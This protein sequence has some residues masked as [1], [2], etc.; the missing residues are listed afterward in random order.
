MADQPAPSAQGT[1]TQ[2]WSQQQQQ[3]EQQSREQPANETGNRPTNGLPPVLS[4]NQCPIPPTVKIVLDYRKG[5]PRGSWRLL[6]ELPPSLPWVFNR[7]QDSFG[8]LLARIDSY[9]SRLPNVVLRPDGGPYLQPTHNTYQKNFVE[10]TEDNY[11]KEFESTWRK[12]ARRLNNIKGDQIVLHLYLY[13]RNADGSSGGMEGEPSPEPAMVASN[14][15][16]GSAMRSSITGSS[17]GLSGSGL[18]NVIRS[19]GGGGSGLG[20]GSS[21]SSILSRHTTATNGIRKSTVGSSLGG[22]GSSHG[23]VHAGRGQGRV[24]LVYGV[25]QATIDRINRA[26]EIQAVAA[27]EGF[28]PWPGPL[29]KVELARHMASA[30]RMPE[31][32]EVRIPE[33]ETFRQLRVLDQ[34]N[35]L[36][37]RDRF[38]GN[39]SGSHSGRT[40]EEEPS[41]NFAAAITS[42]ESVEPWEQEQEQEQVEEQAQEGDED[43]FVQMNIRIHGAIV[44]MEVS[45]DS[46]RKAFAKIDRQSL[47]LT[48]DRNEQ[49]HSEHNRNEYNRDEHDRNEVDQLDEGEEGRQISSESMDF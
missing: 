8:V 48:A 2:T 31:P 45:L 34:R 9:L 36:S 17:S 13:L 25:R 5:A 39:G 33:T 11:L 35:Q 38:Y 42:R 20:L 16:V 7:E 37:D 49:N 26:M 28:I 15:S 30:S 4:F 10:L 32:E 12:E 43:E 24:A 3:E 6:K 46:L 14:R 18:G 21:A 41:R 40:M 27:E 47:G 23:A 22:S 29:V 19:S 1:P 44:P